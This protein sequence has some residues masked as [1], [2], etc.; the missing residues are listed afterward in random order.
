MIINRLRIEIKQLFHYW[1][2][3]R[4]IFSPLRFGG[5]ADF[6]HLSVGIGLNLFSETSYE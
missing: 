1:I 6:L 3:A 4:S 2:T 5:N